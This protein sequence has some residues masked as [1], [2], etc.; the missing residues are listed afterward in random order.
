MR[1]IKLAHL[2]SNLRNQLKF[3]ELLFRYYVVVLL[4]KNCCT[5]VHKILRNFAVRIEINFLACHENPSGNHCVQIEFLAPLLDIQ[6]WEEP[7][8]GAKGVDK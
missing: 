3:I 2:G 5:A 8:I 6:S 4:M 1:R 7:E